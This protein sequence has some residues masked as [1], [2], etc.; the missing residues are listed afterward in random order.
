MKNH[1]DQLSEAVDARSIRLFYIFCCGPAKHL[2]NLSSILFQCLAKPTLIDLCL[3]MLGISYFSPYTWV[4]DHLAKFFKQIACGRAPPPTGRCSRQKSVVWE[5]TSTLSSGRKTFAGRSNRRP[6]L[7]LKVL[8]SRQFIREP[9]FYLDGGQ[10][11]LGCI[12]PAHQTFVR[13]ICWKTSRKRNTCQV[14]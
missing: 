12:A 6:N 10:G 14:P 1:R 5:V 9:V 7:R 11:F 8:P 3:Y 4:G 2:G 13:R